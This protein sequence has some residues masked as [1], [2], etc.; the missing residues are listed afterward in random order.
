MKIAFV[1]NFSLLTLL[2]PA[3]KIQSPYGTNI[4]LKCRRDC[5]AAHFGY[6]EIPQSTYVKFL[7]YALGLPVDVGDA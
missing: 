1:I 2:Y 7:V 3:A 5:P 6:M 4:I